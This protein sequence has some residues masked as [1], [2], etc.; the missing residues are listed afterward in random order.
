M[1]SNALPYILVNNVYLVYCYTDDR[2]TLILNQTLIQ[3]KFTGD[4]NITVYLS[5]RRDDPL[6]IASLLSYMV[7]VMVGALRPISIASNVV[8]RS[9]NVVSSTV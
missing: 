1:G 6:L 2:E 3:D 4:Y 5:L 8:P 7:S 9:L